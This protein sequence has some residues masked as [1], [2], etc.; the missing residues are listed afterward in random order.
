MIIR[1]CNWRGAPRSGL[2]NGGSPR[3]IIASICAREGVTVHPNDDVN[4]SQSSNDTFPTAMHVAIGMMARDTLLPG[5]EKLSA[6]L[7]AKSH[8]F[9]D[10]IKIGRTHTQDAT[11]LTLGQEFSGYAKQVERGIERV[12]MCL[13]HIYE[14]AQGGTAVDCE[15][16]IC[17][18]FVRRDHMGPTDLSLDAFSPVAFVP[19]IKPVVTAAAEAGR[20][21]FTVQGFNGRNLAID[22][23]GRAISRAITADSVKF[24]VGNSKQKSVL[25]TI[26][27][28]GTQVFSQ[29]IALKK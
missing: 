9:K 10:I 13:P 24:Y 1:P 25:A 26:S 20:V 27:D 2:A 16:T 23:G 17:G 21:L 29:N 11:P 12:K 4:M 3:R 28:A 6:A 7:W 22:F 14:L 18:V 15:K 5:L 19:A 8:E